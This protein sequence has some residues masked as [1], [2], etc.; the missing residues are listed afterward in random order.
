MYTKDSTLPAI[1]PAPLANTHKK[2]LPFGGGLE[3]PG[4]GG[5]RTWKGLLFQRHFHRAM[6]RPENLGVNLRSGETL[7]Q[8]VG[9][10]E[11]VDAPAGVLLASVEAV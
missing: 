6:V 1:C 2:S 11:I 10:D 5:A 3:G 7:A 8:A 4:L 9:D